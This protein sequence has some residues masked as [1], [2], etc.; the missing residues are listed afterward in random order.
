MTNPYG[1]QQQPG[2]GH[3][4]QHG[5]PAPAQRRPN[6]ATAIIA[7]VLGLV[8]AGTTG[9]LTVAELF[10]D[11][12]AAIGIDD[13]PGGV[14][15]FYGLL[16]GCA[17]FALIGSLIT[18]FRATAGAILLLIGGLLGVVAVFLEPVFSALWNSNYGRYFEAVFDFGQSE[19]VLRFMIMVLAPLTLILAVLP[20]TFRYLGYKPQAQPIY[21]PPQ[22]YPPQQGW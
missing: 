5:Y 17:V 8:L 21:G 10:I 13:L 18:F 12:P 7:A 6:G 15:T 19:A 9:Y 14:L 11:L 1:Y 3:P 2:P 22:G 20:T 16:T 4:G